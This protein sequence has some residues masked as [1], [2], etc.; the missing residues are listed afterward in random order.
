MPEHSPR[1]TVVNDNPEYLQLMHAHYAIPHAA[2]AWPG[3]T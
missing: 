1:I 2:T 3:T